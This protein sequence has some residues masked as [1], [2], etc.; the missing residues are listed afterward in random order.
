MENNKYEDIINLPHHVST[1][2]P[3]MTLEERSAQF[4]PFA[5]LTGFEDCVEETA[6]LTDEKI[7]I[8][9][10]ANELLNE[11]I[12]NIIKKIEKNPIIKLTYFIP[13]NRK[14]GGKYVTMEE[15]I[16]KIDEINQELIFINGT[17]IKLYNVIDIE[18]KDK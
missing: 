8:S 17:K 14:S 9:E 1:R 7:D 16:K 12:K 18:L 10:D 13:D 3:Q 5:A 6:R 2:H 4:A 15:K 11:K